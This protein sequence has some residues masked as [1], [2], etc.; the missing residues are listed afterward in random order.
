MR[1]SLI[2]FPVLLVPFALVG[3]PASQASGRASAA[4]ASAYE[5]YVACSTK[6]SAPASHSCGKNQPKTAFF[7]SKDAD[8]TYKVCVKFPGR[9]EPLCAV[10]QPAK[11]G[12]KYRNS[13]TS[14]KAGKHKVTWYVDGEKVGRF[15]FEVRQG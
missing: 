6:K 2:L 13:I 10:D 3:V 12:E 7:K 9:P 8:V 15:V 14:T 4:S 1:F 11:Q 5:T